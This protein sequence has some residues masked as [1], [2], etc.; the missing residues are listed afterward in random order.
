[1]GGIIAV[2]EKA[3]WQYGYFTSAQAQ[4]LGVLPNKITRLVRAGHWIRVRTG[5]YR[6]AGWP[7]CWR[8]RMMAASLQAGEGALLSHR[9]AAALWGLECTA[10]RCCAAACGTAS[11]SFRSR[12]RSSI[13]VPVSRNDGIPRRAFD[14]VRRRKLVSSFELRRCLQEHE[15]GRSAGVALYRH[16]LERRLGKTPPGTVIAAKVLDLLVGAGLPEPESEAWVTIGGRRYRIDLAYRRPKIAIECLGKIGHLNEKS[17]EEDPVRN[18]DF[19]IDGW[20]QLQVTWW[21]VQDR[22][23]RVVADVEEALAR[24]GGA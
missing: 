9:S 24:R 4:R 21:R 8:G 22:P 12:R 3:Q 13:C 10:E 5:L 2:A 15:P 23:D 14:D 17:F 7:D 20:L 11:R 19:A 6:L 18:N 1:M 16:L